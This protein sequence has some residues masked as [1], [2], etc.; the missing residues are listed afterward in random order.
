MRGPFKVLIESMGGTLGIPARAYGEVS[1]P[2]L[3]ARPDFGVDATGVSAG[4]N[5]RIG[6]VELKKPSKPIP[7]SDFLDR[8]DRE[9]WEKFQR[10]PNILYS[11]GT[12]WALF[13]Y[14]VQQGPTVEISG[15][16]GRRRPKHAVGAE[17][18]RLIWD[19]LSW[20][21]EP[22][23]TLDQLISR[24]ADLCRQLRDEVAEIIAEER[25][26]GGDRPF[27]RLAEEWRQLLFPQL[28]SGRDFADAYAQTITFALIL[29][30][31]S[32]AQFSG[33]SVHEIS[34]LLGKRHPFL[35]EAFG[36]L[37]GSRTAQE[38]TILPTLIRVLEPIDWQRMMRG[39]QTAYVDLYETFLS[40]YDPELRKE[41]GSYYTPEPVTRFMADFV[42]DVLKSRMARH[43]GL[44][45]E[46]VTTVDPAMGTGT[47][48]ASVM[49]S[50]AGTLSD[51]F[52]EVHA[53]THLKEL[54]RDRLVGFERSTAPFAVAEL[55]LHQQLKEQ[56]GTEVPEEHRRFLVNTLDDPHHAYER[57]GLRYEEIVRF[58]DEANRIK[59][60]T[61][62]MVVIGNPP[63]IKDARQQDPAPW[64]EARRSDPVADP[65][66]ARPSMDEFRES[67]NGRLEYKLSAVGTYFWR[68]ATWKV[69]DAHPEQP[70]GIVAFVSTSAYLTQSA[71]A[72]MR[73]YLRTTA[74]EGWVIDL[75]PEGHRP[76]G[77]TRIFGGVQQPV[78]IGIFARYGRPRPG[79]P[80]RVWHTRLEGERAAKFGA[81]DGDPELRLDG[82]RWQKCEAEWTSPFVPEESLWRSHPA[83]DDL[84]P[85][86]QTG[87]NP[88]R[89]WVY[90]PDRKT[91]LRRWNRLASA[92]PEDKNRLFKATQ[93]RWIERPAP[94]LGSL[95]KALT[96]PPI[97][98]VSF[99]S[100]DR[101]Y[102]FNDERCVDRLRLSL[103][104]ASGDRQ[105][106][107]VEQHAHP[108][109]TG[110]GLVF[111]S[112]VPNVHCFNGRGGRVLPLYRDPEGLSP[113]LARGLLPFLS[114]SL[115]L[116][117]SPDDLIAYIAAT[118]AHPG[119]T[120]AFRG[121]LTVPGIRVPLTRDPAMWASAVELGREVIWLHTYG[122]RFADTS[123]GRPPGPPRLPKDRRPEVIV[124]IP[125]S[126]TAMPDVIRHDSDSGDR[127]RR[128]YV[129]GGV[130]SPV[131]PE[132]WDYDVG[133][134]RVVKKWFSSRQRNPRNKRRGSPLDDIRPERWTPRFT[135]ELLELLTVLTRLVE[136]EP[137]QA[138]FLD[139]ILSGPLVTVDGLTTAGVLPIKPGLRKPPRRL[140]QTELP[141]D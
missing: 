65:I 114:Q 29:A 59:K 116:A 57:F 108:F 1:L 121:H 133:G 102:L 69:F 130:I 74:D 98:P 94:R 112:L 66:T 38:S 34:E 71:F 115:E 46:S 51:T 95:E 81:L 87:V 21:P 103:W 22:N 91:L 100:F 11:N 62:V 109:A 17:F 3:Q 84:L 86:R 118:V 39:E 41:T 44:A 89:T 27:T 19:F 32:G 18:E 4:P 36:I 127:G 52:G 23:Y 131:L 129:G 83:M 40:R 141:L 88:N 26:N 80:A 35:G 53:R 78:C 25:A 45:D 12:Q 63:Y 132:V 125:D 120:A 9:Q 117:V 73:R 37:T 122:E 128:L 139:E 68:W 6:Y 13:R 93:S 48:L 137:R 124:E 61:P 123:A 15:L 136:L 134:M 76:P 106:Y 104:N 8:H 14:G 16:F 92:A 24:T 70:S 138:E 111:S 97:A 47:F 60:A 7:P 110:P 58:R 42:D 50:V 67:G 126:P 30:R 55:R 105:I 113:N 20:E 49:N 10:L 101:Q 2:A 96:P 33:R 31:E 5:N 77:R 107:T 119:Y 85:W 140:G 75:S 28:A 43:R 64:L 79:E 90:A 82:A 99:R 72:G 54:Y 135:D 56:Y